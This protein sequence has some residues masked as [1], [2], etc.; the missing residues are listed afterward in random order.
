MPPGMKVFFA[1]LIAFAL[2]HAWC[3]WYGSYTAKPN[4]LAHF[5]SAEDSRH[6]V[7][8]FFGSSLLAFIGI[9]A[10]WG[11]GAFS[12]PAYTFARPELAVGGAL[13]VCLISWTRS[14]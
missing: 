12:L 5:A 1:V 4:F 9:V 11:C 2:F 10:A 13:I 14:F 3:C 6:A 7:L 8:V